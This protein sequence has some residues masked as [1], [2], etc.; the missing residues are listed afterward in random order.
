MTWV[1]G[2]QTFSEGGDVYIFLPD[3]ELIIQMRDVM[4]HP[5]LRESARVVFFVPE[6]R[7]SVRC[8]SAS[9][10]PRVRLS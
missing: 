3:G 1:E 5:Q 7:C 10:E 6:Y 2:G 4:W 8:L 9:L